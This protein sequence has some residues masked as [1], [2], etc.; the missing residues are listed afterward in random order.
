MSSLTAI[1][2]LDGRYQ[3]KTKSLA[4]YFSETALIK[5]R[6]V[7]EVKYL[8]FLLKVIKKP[9]SVTTLETEAQRVKDIEKTTHHDV[10]AVEYYLR[11]KLANFPEVFPYIHLGLTSEDTNSCAYGL[12]LKDA[13]KNEMLPTLKSLISTIADMA[14]KYKS[15]PMM[16]RTH[17]QPAVPTTL[18]KELM[19]FALRLHHE[20]QTLTNL[21][22]EAKISGAVGNFSALQCAYPNLD[23]IKTTDH[24]IKE[25]GLTPNHCTTQILPADSC[26][27]VFQSFHLINSILIGFNQDI[28]R[29]I[30]DGYFVQQIVKAETGSSTMP[31]KVNPID[32][33]NSEGNLGLA[34]ALFAFFI[35]KLPI[36]RLQR[37]LSD[38]TVKRNIGS[39]FAYG[40]LAYSSCISGL[41]K[42]HPDRER[43]QQELHDHW[44]IITEG[45]QTILR[46]N[47][48]AKAYESVKDFARGKS[49]TS[50]STHHFIE[51][52]SVSPEVKQQLEALSPTTYLGLAEQLVSDGLD[53]IKTDERKS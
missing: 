19:V 24:F 18:G 30:S 5:Y 25:L 17:G 48:D 11:E 50:E 27:K 40:L 4:T 15:E 53:Q 10:K 51:S 29:Y 35:E 22:I 52:L 6:V 8:E 43:L 49:I 26:I 41:H 1:S 34:N 42:I 12:L 28:W 2:P 9:I 46:A 7:V 20:Y 39:A 14:D 21:P 37:D 44:E 31:Q 32:F 13:L 38:S 45:I 33:E 47:G 16:A 36:S 3:S 23:W